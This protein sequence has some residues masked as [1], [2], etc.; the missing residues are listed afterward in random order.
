MP[1][2]PF[3]RKKRRLSS[4][5]A[6]TPTAP[7]PTTTRQP[8]QQQQQHEQQQTQARPAHVSDIPAQAIARPPNDS[9]THII[10]PNVLE[11]QGS[12]QH[13]LTAL[14]ELSELEQSP[15]LRPA[16]VI[17]P[18][19]PYTLDRPSSARS[20]SHT[21]ALPASHDK[22]APGRRLSNKRKK[23]QALREEEIRQM[24]APMQIPKRPAANS[25]H[26]LL[27]RD[28]KK[29]R[30]TLTKRPADDSRSSNVSLPLP[31]SIHSNRSH[32]SEQRAW[33]IGGMS[34]LN[35]R[36]TVRVSGTFTSPPSPFGKRAEKMGK[37][38]E[39]ARASSGRK[40][41]RKV[42]DLADDLN[43]TELRIL[44][45]RDQRR[46]EQK[47][48]EQHER[49]DRKLRRRAEK[50]REEDERRAR[51]ARLNA[52]PPTAI[53]PAF[54]EQ[55]PD[56]EFI[57]STS[58]T[59]QG[60]QPIP[61]MQETPI[62]GGTYLRYPPREDIPQNP[63]V[64]PE[65]DNP[66]TAAGA[67]WSP[68]HTPLDEPVLQTARAVRLSAGHMSPPA[69]PVPII[70]RETQPSPS[71][72]E[73]SYPQSQRTSSHPASS[74]ESSRRRPSE[75]GSRRVGPSAWTNIFRRGLGSNRTSEDKPPSEFSFVNTS[76]ESMS[77][78]P[79]PA[80]LIGPPSSRQAGFPTRTQ[81][82]FREDL[83]ELPISPP[84]SRVQS[85][86]LSVITAGVVAARRAKHSAD[87]QPKM[88][89]QP[90]LIR[91]DSPAIFEDEESTILSQSYGS[92]DSEGSWI[93][94]RLGKRTSHTSHPH[95]SLGSLRKA[96]PEFSGSFDRLPVPEHEFFAALT[97][98]NG[99]RRASA[100]HAI[101]TTP[102]AEPSPEEAAPLRQATARR[103]PT[104]VH[105]DPRFK[106]REG[107]LTEYQAA[108]PVTPSREG[109]LSGESIEHSPVELHKAQSVNYGRMHG[110][111]KTLSA[112]SAK[113]LEIAPKRS[114]S[115]STLLTQTS[116]RSSPRI[117]QE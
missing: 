11:R 64:D 91:N 75:S 24:S 41:R 76:R 58:L 31:E 8:A 112:G 94:G 56:A 5:A 51:D 38:P 1:L 26:D 80:H 106:S 107:L 45:E 68:I 22:Q 88:A 28:S 34:I 3:G 16:N 33:E 108:E 103:R 97:P 12:V 44:M 104:V 35:P 72:P 81:S 86:E 55:Q 6:T 37:L 19:H 117:P 2:W 74:F 61:E 36:P 54:R 77:K 46:K 47:A 84:A 65:P 14:P 15:H 83:P 89:D 115:V 43:S 109:S 49:L 21:L 110:H 13:D 42:A 63:F 67:E 101:E 40:D 39:L 102:T 111:G 48:S 82:K 99:S 50:Q 59:K 87:T 85:P 52:T 73:A 25:G 17:K 60:K 10:T 93:S 30:R 18:V 116:P 53:H 29:A 98:D 9:S 62:K 92:V 71:L 7:A 95:S 105:N 69:S 78:Q 23:D 27:R 114:K 20:R 90:G 70:Q 32:M 66:F 96:K 57:T 113:M 100:E 79:I 4:T